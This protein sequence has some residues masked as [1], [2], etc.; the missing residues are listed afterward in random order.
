MELKTLLREHGYSEFIP[1]P[2]YR[3]EALY[4]YRKVPGTDKQ[5]FVI[6]EWKPLKAGMKPSYE[7]EITFE[8]QFDMWSTMKYYG[9]TAQ[10]VAARLSFM[11]ESLKNSIATMGGN[12]LHYRFDGSD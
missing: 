8:V 12:P 6:K 3:N 2:V 11:E 9:L 7:M 5:Q 10:Q 1:D 4:C